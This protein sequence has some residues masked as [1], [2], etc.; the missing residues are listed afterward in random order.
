MRMKS[1]LKAIDERVWLAIEKWWTPLVTRE[2]DATY[3]KPVESWTKAE[4]RLALYNPK[5]LH[6]IFF[7]YTGRI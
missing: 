3:L 2:G 6:A 5:G 1:A 7:C 4:H